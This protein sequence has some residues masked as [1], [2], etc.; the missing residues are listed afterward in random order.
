MLTTKRVVLTTVL[1]FLFGIFCM[2]LATNNP[3]P[4]NVLPLSTRVLIVISRGLLGF[5]I[6]ISA[7][8]MSWWL[9]GIVLGLVLSIPMMVPVL[10]N[11][12]IALGTLIMGGIY[13]ILIELI[14][15]KLFK[16][17]SVGQQA[18]S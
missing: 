6:G 7:L 11:F 18:I 10:D 3:D 15:V 2:Y 9:H 14:T 12:F 13:G 17:P 8:R 1:G 4:A 5:T 16:A